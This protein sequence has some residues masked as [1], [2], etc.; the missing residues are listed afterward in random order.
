MKIKNLFDAKRVSEMPMPASAAANKAAQQMELAT[1]SKSLNN[2]LRQQFLANR[3]R[4]I[5]S[6]VMQPPHL[7]VSV[8]ANREQVKENILKMA[9]K[10]NHLTESLIKSPRTEKRKSE[11]VAYDS[12]Q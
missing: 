7:T 4:T 6:N 8:N 1:I 5:V 11:S 10:A 2:E 3:K 9:Q 12:A